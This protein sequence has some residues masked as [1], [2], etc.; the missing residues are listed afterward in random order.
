MKKP[1]F[2]TLGPV[3]ALAI[4]LMIIQIKKKRIKYK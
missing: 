2:F 3:A 4:A 1:L